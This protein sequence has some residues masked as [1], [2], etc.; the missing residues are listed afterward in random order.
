M[1]QQ[2]T[3]TMLSR[4][5]VI[6]AAFSGPPDR[7]ALAQENTHPD[8]TGVVSAHQRAQTLMSASQRAMTT[9]PLAA[10]DHA[11]QAHALAEAAGDASMEHRAL[12]CLATAEEGMGLFAEYMKTTLRALHLAQEL[13]DPKAIAEDLRS[14]SNAYRLNGMPEKA[15]E[16]ARNSLAMIL[17]TQRG[18]AV[19]EAQRFL[20]QALL[21]AGRH[22]EVMRMAEACTQK[23]KERSD[24]MEEAR[25][26]HLVGRSLL[27]QKKYADAF[28]YLAKAERPLVAAGTTKELVAMAM[29]KA[30]AFIGMKR[31]AEAIAALDEAEELAGG[32]GT[33]QQAQRLTELRYGSALARGQWETALSLLQR[34]KV[35]SDSVNLARLDL[36]MAR[37]QV[38][39]QL[40]RKEQANAELRSENARH[41]E[42]IAGEQLNNKYLLA[43][44]VVLSVLLTA[45]F[46]SSRHNLRMIGRMKLKNAVIRK[47]HDEIHSKNLELQ[48]Q[49]MR[50]AETL[51][52]EEE[53]ELMI[54]EIHHRVKN[55]LQVVDSL[56]QIEATGAEAAV[57]RVLKEAQGR[58]RSMA[59][60]HE[61]IYRS[62][63]E[64]NGDLQHHLEH[65][66]RNILVA[67]G[68]HDR[69]SVSVSATLPAFNAETLMPLTLVVNEL[70]TNSVKY[71]FLEQESGRISIVVRTAGNGYELLFSDD[72]AGMAEN[73][74]RE[75]S[76]GL[77]LVQ[78]LAGQLNGEVRF[79]KG[80]G[81]T[82]CLT[83]S[84]DVQVLRLAS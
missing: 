5:M 70:F 46:F 81:T 61:H 15:V 47:Q 60:V 45:L 78:M 49:N 1:I 38:T 41:A 57:Q 50:L 35:R 52:S 28:T 36:Q 74:F 64:Q 19:D 58:I 29:D 55:N 30:E 9:D 25:L 43:G 34:I 11:V 16:E 2:W 12:Q 56:L 66:A 33:W 82:V 32:A 73:A 62:Q 37:M 68:C 79:L 22:D 48:R 31:H 71:A 40:D 14:L 24:A 39:Y 75:R 63:G 27:V 77:E 8:L 69:I 10:H 20:I 51:L 54:K 72:G 26:A 53:K 17:P 13:G 84:P 21:L 67:H 44:L 65:L 18:T 83:F 6:I 4:A 80:K 59:L 3:T 42:I 7:A 76:F 23:A